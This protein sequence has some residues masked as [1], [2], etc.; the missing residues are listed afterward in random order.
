M[1]RIQAG[2]TGFTLI[3]LLVVVAIIAVL[4]ALLLPSLA[5]ARESAKRVM[6]MS[7]LKQLGVGEQLYTNDNQ[8]W[9]PTHDLQ[10]S[11]GF[12]TWDQTLIKY[13][14]NNPKL[15]ACPDDTTP[16]DLSLNKYKRSYSQNAYIQGKYSNVLNYYRS[17]WL[18]PD[19]VSNFKA[20]DMFYPPHWNTSVDVIPERVLLLAE[21]YGG[22]MEGTDYL[23]F[24]EANY[25]LDI[26][27]M[28]KGTPI[29]FG[30]N[31]V[32]WFGTDKFFP[33]A[34]GFVAKDV[35]VTIYDPI[36]ME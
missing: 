28:G 8:V 35:I 30:D 32:Q 17:V 34:Y 3:E 31:H 4:I 18:G 9:A 24:Y 15:F 16:D 33:S 25:M 19:N 2:K 7:N 20:V 6:C 13:V 29:L 23:A 10:P 5:S 14:G 27:H 12:K 22:Y 1:K 11:K 36:T 26:V 21:R